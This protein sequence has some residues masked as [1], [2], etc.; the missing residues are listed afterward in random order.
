[1]FVMYEGTDAGKARRVTSSDLKIHF[2]GQEGM[3]AALYFLEA[4]PTPRAFVLGLR[5][6][7]C[8]RLA[9]DGAVALIVQRIVRYLVLANVIP[10]LFPRPIGHRVQFDDF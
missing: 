6:L 1:M 2:L 9:A 8:A 5:D 4:D 10:Y 3:N 7:P